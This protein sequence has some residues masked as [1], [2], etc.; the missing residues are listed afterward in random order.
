MR[1]RL[2]S[3]PC[4]LSVAPFQHGSASSRAV[5]AKGCRGR[6]HDVD[7]P[8]PPPSAEHSPPSPPTSHKGARDPAP[9]VGAFASSPPGSKRERPQLT[10]DCVARLT[11]TAI[12]PCRRDTRLTQA[13]TPVYGVLAGQAPQPASLQRARI[14]APVMAARRA[15]V[16]VALLVLLCAHMG[17]LP[18]VGRGRH[19][20]GA[21][22]GGA[23]GRGCRQGVPL[24]DRA[25]ASQ[26]ARERAPTPPWH[27][28]CSPPRALPGA[29][30]AGPGRRPGAGSLQRGQP[31]GAD[32]GGVSVP[33]PVCQRVRRAAERPNV[34]EP[35]PGGS[36][37]QGHRRDGGPGGP[38]CG[39]GGLRGRHR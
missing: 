23:A 29:R 4:V 27:P 8:S 21:G 37:Q 10:R 6:H 13:S 7:P 39:L 30:A 38:G 2:Q 20:C 17:E 35:G 19:R 5:Y 25:A 15:R 32:A 3:R 24:R 14:T 18:R 31:G 11:P 34:H 9:G 26:A 12:S 16:A 36:Q 1:S 22:S 33:H 28:A